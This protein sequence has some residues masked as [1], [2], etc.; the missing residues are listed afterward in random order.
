MAPTRRCQEDGFKIRGEGALGPRLRAGSGGRQTRPAQGL[1][2]RI[3]GL[4][5]KVPDGSVGLWVVL[6]LL[7][8]FLLVSS[9]ARSHSCAALLALPTKICSL[10]PI[11]QH[12]LLYSTVKVWEIPAQLLLHLC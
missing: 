1:S 5:I 9:Q 10:G 8:G 7:A 2:G 12:T 11:I 3:V 4:L 6:P